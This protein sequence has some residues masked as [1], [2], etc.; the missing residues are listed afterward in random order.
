MGQFLTADDLLALAPA[1]I[2]FAAGLLVLVVDLFLKGGDDP[3]LRRGEKA[4]LPFAALFAV[5]LAFP[6]LARGWTQEGAFVRGWMAG[7]EGAIR[8]DRPGVFL[9]SIVLLATLLSIAA[10]AG[11]TPRRRIHFGEYYALLLLASGAMVLLVQAK[12]LIV[13]FLAIETMSIAL[14]VLTGFFRQDR[15]SVEGSLK[16]FILGGFSS[17]FLLLGMALFY[18]ATGSMDLEAV[19]SGPE[20]PLS[21]PLLFAAGLGLIGIGIAFKVGAVPFHT[22]VPDAY[23]GAPTAVTGFMAVAVKAAAFAVLVRFA[24]GGFRFDPE[25][26]STLGAIV[27]WVAIA[28]MILGNLVALVQTNVKRMLAY[29]AIAHTGYLLVGI[30][31]VIQGGPE[32]E[33]APIFFYFIPYALM[34]IGSFAVIALLGAGSA[35][36]EELR[37]LVGLGRQAPATAVAFLLFMI[38][39]AGIP[40]MAGFWGK[41]F[42]FREAIRSGAP[43]GLTLAIVGI[44]T[45]IFSMAYYLRPV[46]MM[47]MRREDAPS[48]IPPTQWGARMA[49]GLPAIGTVVLGL[50]PAFWWALSV[51]CS[52]GR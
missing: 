25:V 37:S 26:S 17:G 6:F 5:L 43:Y 14:Y 40:P 18:A 11:Y 46:V 24:R 45:S 21:D 10:S 50:L 32:A 34:T 13:L 9:G 7:L 19:P 3:D 23:E 36:R 8:V 27:S 4:I 52:A 30:A 35:D 31:V 16:Y 28:S 44:A 33:D 22:W 48:P 51:S 41:F 39:F 38:S 12:S 42:I 1:M 29:S 49:I 47:F 15:R 20:N 2:L